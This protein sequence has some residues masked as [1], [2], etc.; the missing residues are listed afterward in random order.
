VWRSL[1]NYGVHAISRDPVQWRPLLAIYYLTYACDFRCPYCSDGAG[2]PY[3][4]LR[5]PFL[6]AGLTLELL[7][8]VRRYSDYLV[9][10]GGEP[11]KHPQV[12]AV[13]EGVERLRFDGVVFTTNGHDLD[14]AGPWLR[15]AVTHLVFSLDTLD[16]ARGDAWNGR[17]P[18][19]HAR[20]VANIERF[21]AVSPRP[22]VILSSV[23]T[24][25]NLEGL[26]AVYE[27]ARSRGIRFAA[28][29]QLVG[30]KAHPGLVDNPGYRC[31]FDFLLKEKRRGAD[32]EGTVP[33]LERMRDLK[34]F[35]C[36]PSAVLALSPAGDVFYP[37]LELGTKAGNLLAE[38]DLDVLR[39]RARERFGP[40]PQCDNRCH[41]ACAL[42]FSVILN[43]PWAMIEE[44]ALLARRRLLS[45]AASRTN[46]TP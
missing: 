45:R 18:G 1:R 19:T 35:D 36:R 9:L 16:S 46:E 5:E 24:P 4:A 38:P 25:D 22:K 28:C 21:L 29:P 33:Y 26:P 39:A 20:I 41:S 12:A 34:K 23:V 37:C 8:H 17:G 30:V 3:H 13:L 43:Q 15:R 42:G 11:L 10:T 2:K 40:E 7:A 14:A 32:I 31:F 6:D 44:V 27:F